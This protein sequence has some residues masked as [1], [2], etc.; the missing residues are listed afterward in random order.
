MRAFCPG[1][2]YHKGNEETF[3]MAQIVFPI[4]SRAVRGREILFPRRELAVR[5]HELLFRYKIL[6]KK[7]SNP[8]KDISEFYKKRSSYMNNANNRIKHS[9]HLSSIRHLA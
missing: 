9:W 3:R 8:N 4:I 5:G 6:K 2:L 1:Y 7:T